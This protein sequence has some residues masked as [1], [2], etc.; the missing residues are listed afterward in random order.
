MAKKGGK[1]KGRINKNT[2]VEMLVGLFNRHEGE[3]MSPKEIFKELNLTSTSARTLCVQILDDMVFDGY[4]ME[5]E[6]RK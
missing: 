2:L 1:T 6:F 3:T 4:I 5:P